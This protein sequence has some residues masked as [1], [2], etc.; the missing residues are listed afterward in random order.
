MKGDIKLS[1]QIEIQTDIGD[2]WV[3]F[4]TD[5]INYDDDG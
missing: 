2:S 1:L 5:K 3:A 4:A